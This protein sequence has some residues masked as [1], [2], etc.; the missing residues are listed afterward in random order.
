M[1]GALSRTVP[2]F[3]P[4]AVTEYRY[5]AI[6]MIRPEVLSKVANYWLRETVA[7]HK[8]APSGRLIGTNLAQI[9]ESIGMP[10]Q[11]WW[12]FRFEMP[13]RHTV[14]VEVQIG[15]VGQW[16]LLYNVAQDTCLVAELDGKKRFANSSSAAFVQT[17]VL[18]DECYKRVQNEC[19]GDAGEDWDRGDI[20]VREMELS[21]RSVDPHAF[22][23]ESNLWPCV[24]DD[25]NG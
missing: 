7:C 15:K 22:E 13:S 23:S 14:G 21:M 5:S 2:L 9:W 16:S 20:I 6:P 12:L 25:V 24:L 8:A 19:A 10:D 17:L 3:R 18:F 11:V 1:I 4:I